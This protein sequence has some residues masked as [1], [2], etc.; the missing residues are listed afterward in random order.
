MIWND[1]VRKCGMY[2]WIGVEGITHL[3][4]QIWIWRSSGLPALDAFSRGKV[5]NL[6]EEFLVKHEPFAEQSPNWHFSLQCDG[7]DH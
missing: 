4:T 3:S 5:N 2:C 6:S 1:T 7:G